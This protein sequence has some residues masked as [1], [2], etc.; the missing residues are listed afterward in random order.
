MDIYDR[1]VRAVALASYFSLIFGTIWL[2]HPTWLGGVL[3]I[4]EILI[5]V[6]VGRWIAYQYKFK[7][8]FH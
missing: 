4:L 1:R 6:A 8:R 3:S 7:G 5:M 2:V